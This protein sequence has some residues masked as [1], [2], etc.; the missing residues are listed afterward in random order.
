MTNIIKLRHTNINRYIILLS[1]LYI[2]KVKFLIVNVDV[3]CFKMCL[4]NNKT[5]KGTIKKIKEETFVAKDNPT[6]IELLNMKGTILIFLSI[7]SNEK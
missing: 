2:N 6:K 7:K 3:F 4:L 1:N 5:E